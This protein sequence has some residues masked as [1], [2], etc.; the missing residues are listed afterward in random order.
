MITTTLKYSF[1]PNGFQH[2]IQLTAGEEQVLIDHL[3]EIPIPVKGGQLRMPSDWTFLPRNRW[4][5][6]FYFQ[7]GTYWTAYD[8][9][10]S[11]GWG[12]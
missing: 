6:A 10:H 5:H 11:Y 7:D 9:W 1:A 8:G 12:E 4:Y 2:E 3:G